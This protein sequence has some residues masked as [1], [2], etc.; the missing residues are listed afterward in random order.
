[1]KD[2]KIR[3]RLF[4]GFLVPVI[5]T[6]INV[7]IGMSSVRSSVGIVEEMYQEE[8]A[9]VREL[10]SNIGADSQ[11]SEELIKAI[12]ESNTLNFWSLTH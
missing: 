9:E 2:V 8:E 5:L 7:Y 1:M 11:K 12:N 3:T 4:I 6:I 10:I